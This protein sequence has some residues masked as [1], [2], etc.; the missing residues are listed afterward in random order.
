MLDKDEKSSNPIVYRH[1]YEEGDFIITD[2]LANL[3]YADPNT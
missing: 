2:N 3:H 1:N